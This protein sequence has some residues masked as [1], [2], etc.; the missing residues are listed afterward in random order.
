MAFDYF[1]WFQG[2]SKESEEA[3]RAL[4][5]DVQGIK[6][7]L[8]K[9]VVLIE[10]VRREQEVLTVKHRPTCEPLMELCDAV[11][12]LQRAFQ[13][14]GLMS[15]QHAQVLQLVHVKL[16][17]FAASQGIQMIVQEGVRFDPGVHEAVANRSPGA[18]SLEVVEVVQP[19]Y[20]QDGKVVRAAK[21]IVG[22]AGGPTRSEGG[23]GGS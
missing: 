6:K 3:R 17:R 13:S 23:T 10:E 1:K 2:K 12:H 16:D 9:Q 20:L 15:R 18:P 22:A 11:Y 21:V 4:L 5:D 7:L 19:G 14:P 8:R